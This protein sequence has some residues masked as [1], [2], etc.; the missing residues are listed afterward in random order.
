MYYMISW[1][2]ALISVWSGRR[3]L[4]RWPEIGKY[5]FESLSWCELAVMYVTLPLLLTLLCNYLD[6]CCCCPQISL[7]W[8]T[9]PYQVHAH[10]SLGWQPIAFF[11]ATNTITIH[12][13]GC[14]GDSKQCDISCQYCGGLPLTNA[15]QDFVD[16]ATN[17]SKFTD[18]EYLNAKQLQAAMRRLSNKCQELQTKVFYFCFHRSWR[19]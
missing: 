2:L 11:K 9:Y 19:Y 3:D 7:P 10:W 1:I 15:F 14:T 17:V 12:A 6:V 18:S 13:D 16:W 4:R 5:I 8:D